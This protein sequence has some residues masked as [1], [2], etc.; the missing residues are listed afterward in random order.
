M[1]DLHTKVSGARPPTGPNYFVFTY[2]FAEKCP[3]Q[4][5]APPPTRVGTPPTGNPASAPVELYA[6]TSLL[7][8]MF[9]N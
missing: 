3:C 7:A 9:V 2:V 4:R 1:A 5:L 6:S 8:P